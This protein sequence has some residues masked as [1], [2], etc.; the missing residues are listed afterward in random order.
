MT[1]PASGT[2]TMSA[3]NTEFGRGNNMGAYRGTSW[4]TD[5]GASGTFSA[6]TIKYSDFYGKRKTSPTNNISLTITSNTAD[7][8]I[9][10]LAGSPAGTSNVT[11][12]INSGVYC[13]ASNVTNYGIRTGSGWVA[14]TVINIICNGNIVGCGGKGGN[15][16]TSN[17]TGGFVSYTSLAGQTGG[18][19][20]LA[21]FNCGITGTGSINGGGGG[22]GGGGNRTRDGASSYYGDGGGGGGGQSFVQ[23]SKGFVYSG[24]TGAVGANGTISGG[25]I[26]GTGS[27][28][29]ATSEGPGAIGGNGGNGGAWGASGAA[30]GA[31]TG[32][33]IRGGAGAA[34]S[35]STAINKN[36]KTVTYSGVTVRGSVVA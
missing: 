32:A 33:V 15:N 24:S 21:E 26:G 22:G 23:S 27:S 31:G 34:S 5:A 25:G 28:A 30:G 2:L 13:Y 35:N 9:F 1:L 6:G 36:G 19:A 10:T 12:T 20:F 18:T 14:G 17:A 29:G 7:V 4:Y 3:I 16:Y 11:V 8:N